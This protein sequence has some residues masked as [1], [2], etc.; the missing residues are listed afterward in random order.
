M[1]SEIRHES[2][3]YLTPLTGRPQANQVKKET[4]H[5][6]NTLAGRIRAGM[7]WAGIPN[8][9]QLSKAADLSPGYIYPI[10]NGTRPGHLQQKSVRKIAAALRVNSGWLATGAGRPT[11]PESGAL[12]PEVPI[13]AEL[14]R[15]I[16]VRAW[17]A[18][19][20]AHAREQAELGVDLVAE[21][22]GEWMA[23]VE[24]A[25]DAVGPARPAAPP[26]KRRDP[27]VD[28]EPPPP[29][30]SSRRE[31]RTGE[32]STPPTPLRHRG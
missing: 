22:W 24:A 12:P 13:P 3:E 10:L 14:D 32:H 11:D 28:S 23:R 26:P 8:G 2:G 9:Q 5:D 6:L 1:S 27:R 21:D 18:A 30:S 16:R 4:A 29:M 19:T 25:L 17:R 15:A 31:P 20:I 7:E